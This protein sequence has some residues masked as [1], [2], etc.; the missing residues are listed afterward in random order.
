MIDRRDLR[1]LVGQL[2]ADFRKARQ[3]LQRLESRHDARHAE[4]L[5]DGPIGVRADD[6]G[7][8]TGTQKRV[9]PV[10]H[11]TQQGLHRR[12][13]DLVSAQHAEVVQLQPLGLGDRHGRCR[14]GRLK[15]DG[16]KDDGL[17]G[18]L[19]CKL[20]RIVTA[21][22]HLTFCNPSVSSDPAEPG[23]RIMSP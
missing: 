20:H 5:D 11:S 3:D 9:D 18:V 17:V 19:S 16:Q 15:T 23:T 2:L 4:P 6:H 7:D 13:D 10:I 1:P 22:D 21:D 12:H 8:M 14:R